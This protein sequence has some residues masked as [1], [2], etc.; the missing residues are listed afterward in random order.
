MIKTENQKKMRNRGK[1]R[2]TKKSFAYDELT[3]K[4]LNE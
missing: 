3:K 1:K 4:T 2:N